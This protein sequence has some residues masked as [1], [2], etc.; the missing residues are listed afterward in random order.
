MPEGPGTDADGFDPV[1]AL[2]RH[3]ESRPSLPAAG[4]PAGTPVLGPPSISVN[5]AAPERGGSGE[6]FVGP[7]HLHVTAEIPGA[8]VGSLDLRA[9]GD[10]LDLR[11]TDRTGRTSV[12]SFDLPAAVESE[13]IVAT[14]HNDVLDVTLLR[15]DA[16]PTRAREGE[17]DA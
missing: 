10:R 13:G 8:D 14:C 4:S 2:R 7:T 17:S 6:V 15:K 1:A 11:V 12:R 3:L 9:T 16:R 5:E